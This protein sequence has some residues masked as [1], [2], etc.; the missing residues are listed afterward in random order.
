MRTINYYIWSE[1]NCR[2]TVDLN[3]STV[4]CLF[5]EVT[6]RNRIEG[7]RKNSCC[8]WRRL[9]L[10]DSQEYEDGQNIGVVTVVHFPKVNA[11]KWIVFF[12]RSDCIS[13]KLTHAT[14]PTTSWWIKMGSRTNITDVLN[15]SYTELS[16]SWITRKLQA[17][18]ICP[19]IFTSK[20][21]ILWWQTCYLLAQTIYSGY[22]PCKTFSL[23]SVML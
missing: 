20:F 17:F 3:S 12:N 10:Y 1:N 9:N 15:N 7:Y 21:W 11:N 4:S 23:L 22:T 8:Q 5:K 13:A 2:K 14:S 19:C 16:D 6:I 18:I